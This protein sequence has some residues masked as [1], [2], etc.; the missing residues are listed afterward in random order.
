M[1]GP[2]NQPAAA[3]P[4]SILHPTN[5]TGRPSEYSVRPVLLPRGTPFRQ[6]EKPHLS[7][8]PLTQEYRSAR[9][10]GLEPPNLLIRAHRARQAQERLAAG[11]AW[12]DSDLVFTTKKGTPI[13]PDNFAH[14]FRRL[15][16]SAGLGHWTPHELGHSAASIML[17]QGTPLWV[18]SEVLGHASLTITKDFYGTGRPRP[19]GMSSTTFS[20]GRPRRPAPFASAPDDLKAFAEDGFG[21]VINTVDLFHLAMRVEGGAIAP[22]EARQL[23]RESSGLLQLD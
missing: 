18:V 7:R 3:S 11:P 5:R 22:E 4:R 2:P 12:A 14:Y 6:H 9:P 23:L 20:T 8:P 10:E 13:D 16:A 17:A 21:L 1:A 15:C 19:C